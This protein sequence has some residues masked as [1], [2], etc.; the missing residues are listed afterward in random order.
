LYTYSIMKIITANNC[1][2]CT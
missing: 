1:Q 2:S